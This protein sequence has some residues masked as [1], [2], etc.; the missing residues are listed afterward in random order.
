MSNREERAEWE[1]A[2]RAAGENPASSEQVETP[3]ELRTYLDDAIN[4]WREQRAQAPTDSDQHTAACYVD[5]FQSVRV[6]VFGEL[7]PPSGPTQ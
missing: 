4:K 1:N 3:D 7:L 2:K 5:A 6:S